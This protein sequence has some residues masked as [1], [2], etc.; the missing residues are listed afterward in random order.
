[1]TNATSSVLR[2]AI[3]KANEVNEA[4]EM[5]FIHNW[6]RKDELSKIADYANMSYNELLSETA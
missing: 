4:F 1:M 2:T 3:R 6:E 5:G